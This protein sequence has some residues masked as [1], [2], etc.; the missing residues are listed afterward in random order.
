MT[1]EPS[2]SDFDFAAAGHEPGQPGGATGVAV[3]LVEGAFA[4]GEVAQMVREP[5]SDHRGIVVL[6]SGALDDRALFLG[7]AALDLDES[8]APT[9]T[10]R[11]VLHVS[12]DGRVTDD[13]GRYVGSVDLTLLPEDRTSDILQVLRERASAESNIEIPRLGRARLLR[14]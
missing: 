7:T 6:S 4:A 13:G 2:R 5:A 12:A 10:T 14:F 11:R 1:R 8:V 3:A 9:V